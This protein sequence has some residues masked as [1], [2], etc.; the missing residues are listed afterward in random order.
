MSECE[1]FSV[2]QEPMWKFSNECN[3]SVRL[4]SGMEFKGILTETIFRK[5]YGGD[6][7]I[8][9]GKWIYVFNLGR[10]PKLEIEEKDIESIV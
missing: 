6:G 9:I 5:D 1:E 3:V 2:K 8:D 7:K 4:K 10:I